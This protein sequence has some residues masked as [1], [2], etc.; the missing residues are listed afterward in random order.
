M[1]TTDDGIAVVRAVGDLDMASAPAFEHRLI[2]EAAVCWGL[3]AD[4]L[5][6]D[7]ADSTG[8]DALVRAYVAC[9]ANDGH[10][11]VVTTSERILR[12]MEVTG[13]GD[14]LYIT[15]TVEAACAELRRR[16]SRP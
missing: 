16:A 9:T 12:V 2:T 1:V 13:Y 6:S 8:L 15:D 5:A 10:F 11:A 4:L 14:V 7:F 3:V